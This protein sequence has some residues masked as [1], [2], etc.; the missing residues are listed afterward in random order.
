[1]K[2]LSQEYTR[3][4]CIVATDDFRQATGNHSRPGSTS[5]RNQPTIDA[6]AALFQPTFFFWWSTHPK[7][8]VIIRGRQG[9]N[10]DEQHY[11]TIR[12]L[13]GAKN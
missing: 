10:R 1:M 2:W 5:P 13:Y 9:G 3:M 4:P 8:T 7:N 6:F 12:Q 11:T